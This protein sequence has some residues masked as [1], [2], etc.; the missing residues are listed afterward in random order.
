MSVK[1]DLPRVI[2]SNDYDCVGF[3]NPSVMTIQAKDNAAVVEVEDSEGKID[4]AEDSI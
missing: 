2:A 3:N 4:L 1:T